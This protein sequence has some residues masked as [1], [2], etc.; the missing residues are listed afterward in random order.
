MFNWF[1]FFFSSRRRHT[2]LVSDWSSDVCSSDL[3]VHADDDTVDFGIR[4]V[5]RPRHSR[6]K[7]CG[8]NGSECELAY[9][10]SRVLHD[11]PFQPE[12][13]SRVDTAGP[14]GYTAKRFNLTSVTGYTKRK[15]PPPPHAS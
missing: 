10:T 6:Q 14:V 1:F 13:V 3:H 11:G 12:Q 2:R 4:L 7:A 9:L 5:G 8:W 15:M